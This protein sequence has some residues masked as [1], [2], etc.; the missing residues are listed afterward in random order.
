M[1]Q[2]AKLKRLHTA[3]GADFDRRYADSMGV[4]AHEDTVKLFQKASMG[5]ADPEVKA[6][7]AKTLPTLRHHLQ[8]ARDLA[9][10]PRRTAT[11]SASGTGKAKGATKP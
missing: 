3:D 4:K 2:K 6:F 10:P 11:P 1:T 5:A 9:P 7:A 8:M